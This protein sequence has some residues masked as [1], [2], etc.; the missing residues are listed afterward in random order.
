MIRK[1]LLAGAAGFVAV[2]AASDRAEAIPVGWTCVGSSVCG[3]LG[4]DG[5]VTSPPAFGPDYAFVTTSRAIGLN[6][7]ALPT[8][9]GQETNGSR[10]ETGIFTLSEG[11]VL[12]FYFN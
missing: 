7:A 10:L 1:L 11:D 4:P 8:P 3:T 12:S 6:S 2:L 5:V 9:T